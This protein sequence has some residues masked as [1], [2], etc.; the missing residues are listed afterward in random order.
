MLMNRKAQ[1][2]GIV[3]AVVALIILVAVLVPVVNNLVTEAE[4]G[5][6]GSTVAQNQT[7]YYHVKTA[8]TPSSNDKI[9][10]VTSVTPTTTITKNVREDKVAGD[11]G[12][13]SNTT[14]LF[15]VNVT[16]VTV[17]NGTTQVDATNFSLTNNVTGTLQWKTNTWNGTTVRIYYNKS[18]IADT[19]DVY[20]SRQCTSCAR[21][22]LFTND[23][24]DVA[25]TV[26]GY[27]DAD[28]WQFNRTEFNNTGWEVT[29]TATTREYFEGADLLLA[30]NLITFALIGIILFVVGAFAVSRL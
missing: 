28:N 9:T 4:L 25:G 2:N 26:L 21:T 15:W 8:L 6:T 10:E 27:G 30:N 13:N 19:F 1:L 24:A 7:G 12:A 20:T 22:D 14:T 3:V 5:T 16:A 11:L 18:F 17:F 29:Y 23:L